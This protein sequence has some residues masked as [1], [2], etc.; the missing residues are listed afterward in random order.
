MA[1]V[2][3]RVDIVYEPVLLAKT[4]DGI[5]LE[6]HPDVYRKGIDSLAVARRLAVAG[7]LLD[8]IDWSAAEDVIRK[9]DGIARDITRH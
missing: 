4:A 7:N 9:H 6:V 8:A 5:F 1:A 3:D 2:G